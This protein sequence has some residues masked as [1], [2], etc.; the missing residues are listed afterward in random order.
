[1]QF[2]EV[3]RKVRREP[4]RPFRLH[5]TDGTVY[6]VRHP[7][8]ILLGRRS[9]VVGLATDPLQKIFD[10]AV[11]IDLFHVVRMDEVEKQ[12]GS[13]GPIGGASG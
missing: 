2:E 10:R 9:A 7:E 6:K 13:N 4:F 11:D 1:M 12:P 3:E 5:M 8:L